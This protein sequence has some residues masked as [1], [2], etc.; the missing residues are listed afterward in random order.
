KKDEDEPAAPHLRAQN[1]WFSSTAVC[2]QQH[3]VQVEVEDST[4]PSMTLDLDSRVA[5]TISLTTP[6]ARSPSSAAFADQE[7]VEG[8]STYEEVHPA[9]SRRGGRARSCTIE[10]LFSIDG[11]CIDKQGEDDVE[12]GSSFLLEDFPSM[13]GSSAESAAGWIMNQAQ[14]AVSWFSHSFS[15]SPGEE[16]RGHNE[17]RAACHQL[18]IGTPDEK[19]TGIR[20]HQDTGSLR[21]ASSPWVEDMSPENSPAGA[22]PAAAASDFVRRVASNL[23]AGAVAQ[24]EEKPDSVLSYFF[25]WGNTHIGSENLAAPKNA[26]ANIGSTWRAEG[27][28]ADDLPHNHAT[29]CGS[30]GMPSGGTQKGWRS[31]F[32]SGGRGTWCPSRRSVDSRMSSGSPAS[33]TRKESWPGSCD[34]STAIITPVNQHGYNINNDSYNGTGRA[35]GHGYSGRVGG[36]GNSKIFHFDNHNNNSNRG[37]RGAGSWSSSDMD[38]GSREAY[39]YRSRTTSTLTDDREGGESVCFI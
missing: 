4:M 36:S 27:G 29:G 28:G 5:T 31:T 20:I 3:G 32:G 21:P 15:G 16:A 14:S 26:H 24:L 38:D 6:K 34:S 2:A 1:E 8:L 37:G 33:S 25:S 18:N 13:R 39:D 10:D 12:G 22:G 35:Q 9:S 23:K 17:A 7:V 11:D 30:N 19:P